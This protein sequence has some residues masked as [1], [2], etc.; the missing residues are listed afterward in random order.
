MTKK[1]PKFDDSTHPRNLTKSKY[2]ELKKSIQRNY[3]Q[4]AKRQREFWKQ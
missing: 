3:N 4:T 1:V 2:D